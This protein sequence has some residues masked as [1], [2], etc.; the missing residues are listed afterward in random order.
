[1]NKTA[2]S[3]TEPI[4]WILLHAYWCTTKFPS[5]TSTNESFIQL[6]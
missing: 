1:V 3:A 2:A 6:I 4:K 5:Y